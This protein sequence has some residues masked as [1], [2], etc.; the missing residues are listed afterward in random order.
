MTANAFMLG[1]E[2]TGGKEACF[3]GSPEAHQ[4]YHSR[5]ISNDGEMFA[6]SSGYMSLLPLIVDKVMN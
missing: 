4:G 1:V 2:R 6:E 3:E 5:R